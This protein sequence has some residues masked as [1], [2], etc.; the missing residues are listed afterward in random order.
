VARLF[1]VDGMS[2]V[3]RAYYAIQGLTND[4][5][6]STNAVYGLAVMLRKLIEDEKPDYLGL[7]L[8]LFGPTVRHEQFADYKATRRKMP[9]DLVDQ[10]PYVHELCA[11]FR[12]P[13]L[14]YEGYEADDVIGTLARQAAEQS[15]EVI[16]VSI[17]KDM[18]QL[19]NDRVRVLDTRTA[20]LYDSGLVEKKW[21]VKPSQMVDVLALVGDSSDNIPGAPGI[22]EKGA[23]SLISEHGSLDELLA[24]RDEVK[25]K[26]Y[27]ESLKEHEQLIKKSREL[28]KIHLDLPLELDLSDLQ[29]R[30]PDKEKVREL[31]TELGFRSLIAE[32]LP[33]PQTDQ[34]LELKQVDSVEHLIRELSGRKVAVAL[35]L[36]DSYELQGFALASEVGQ[37]WFAGGEFL[38]RAEDGL[39]RLLTSKIRWLAHDLKP[40]YLLAYHKGWPVPGLVAGDTML[41]GYLLNPNS[42]DFSLSQMCLDHVGLRLGAETRE[43]YSLIEDGNPR[44]LGEQASACLR[45]AEELFPVIE[46]QGLTSLL[47][48]IELPLVGVLAEMESRGVRIDTAQLHA[49]SA[50]VADELVELV[51]KV[52]AMA[53]TEFNLN[54]PRQLS[55][56]LF[57]KMGLPAPRKTGKAG[58]YSTG[59]EVLEELSSDFEIAGLLL[60]YR[61][62]SKLKNTYLDALPK[63]VNPASGRIH[64]SYNQTVASTGRLS[65]SNPNL[66]NIPIRSDLGR[67]IR[68]AFVPE[69]GYRMLTAD[70]SQIEL[71]VMAHLSQDPV[72][73]EAFR[74]GEDIH[75][76]TAREV[77]GTDSGLHER[78]LRRRAKVINFGIMYGLSAFGLAKSL[79]ISRSEA[80]QFIDGYFERYRGVSE[81]TR[82]T[83]ESAQ[84]DGY[85]KTLFGRIRQIPEINSKNWSIREF[86]RRTAINA[87]IQGTAADLIKMAMVRI[88][89]RTH[90]EKLCSRLILQVHDELVWEVEKSEVKYLVGL[91]QSEMES[92]AEL[93][94]PLRV[95]IALGDSWYEAK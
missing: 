56:V 58:H 66:Q 2:H 39:S 76:R 18:F 51:K 20:S 34:E 23:R 10:I 87:P 8:D 54:S 94:I 43:Q 86:A 78:E 37:V 41:M 74:E 95:E 57:E 85:V 5:G 44:L 35:W 16:I 21:G 19:V 46:E 81:W 67:K 33:V 63:L 48:D 91:V 73:I 52:H 88:A 82:A 64:T 68:K 12:I 49:M 28:I 31:F 89:D 69:P 72:L 25:R 90:Q 15:L 3:Y 1:L 47:Q 80:Q 9:Q 50:Q 7:A 14:S 77:F 27:R 61:E 60:E 53:G 26:S 11:A 30:E 84:R 17:D 32:F 6:M 83:L 40:L 13:V 70:Y 38:A 92:V 65:S 93:S 36:G 4:K 79:K 71:R 62:L 22:G 75:E 42:R 45:L 24:R 55:E 29:T 59:V